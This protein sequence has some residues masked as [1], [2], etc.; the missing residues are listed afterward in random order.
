MPGGSEELRLTRGSPVESNERVSSGAIGGAEV[1]TVEFLDDILGVEIVIPLVLAFGIA[2]EP[3]G[4]D[5]VI[6]R[7]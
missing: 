3:C 5:I 1:S 7:N 4:H 2:G 6:T